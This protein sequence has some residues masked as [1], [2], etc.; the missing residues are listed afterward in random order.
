MK[1]LPNHILTKRVK[2]L[3]G[4]SIIT[5]VLLVVLCISAISFKF[6]FTK[7]QQVNRQLQEHNKNVVEMVVKNFQILNEP[8]ILSLI[9]R[10]RLPKLPAE[11]QVKLAQTIYQ[12]CSTYNIPV[13]Y[14]CAIIE[15]ESEW[16]PEAVNSSS[17]ALGLM[18]LLRRYAMPHMDSFGGYSAERLKDPCINVSVGIRMLFDLKRESEE[19]VNNDDWIRIFTLYRWGSL[20]TDP[21]Y[22][23]DIIAKSEKY[24]TRFE[25][26][27]KELFT[28]LNSF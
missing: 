27:V 8:T 10:E 6:H 14:V 24:R 18:Q 22:A 15:K 25:A 9:I 7:S 2:R 5:N 4:A 19:L 1:L 20:S 21:T 26:P 28:K 11:L 23:N 13:Y 17:G 16:N 3:T 12:Q